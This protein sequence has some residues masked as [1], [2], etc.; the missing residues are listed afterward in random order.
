MKKFR[1]ILILGITFIIT[2]LNVSFN[3]ENNSID[4]LLLQSTAQPGP[5]SCALNGYKTWSGG[6][7]GTKGKNCWCDTIRKPLDT[8]NVIQ[9]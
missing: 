6:L 1:I 4:N 8:C 7:F 9:D 2:S 3:N 5:G